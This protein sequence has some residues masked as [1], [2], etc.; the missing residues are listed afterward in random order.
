MVSR[1]AIWP[2]F[3][4]DAELYA[5]DENLEPVRYDFGILFEDA[6]KPRRREARQAADRMGPQGSA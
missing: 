1:A 4:L 5:V 2:F 6:K 3:E